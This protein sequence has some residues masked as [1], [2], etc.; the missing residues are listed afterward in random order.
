MKK[1]L[2]QL[3]YLSI[4]FGLLTACTS[5]D[6]DDP[7]AVNDG[8]GFTIDVNT[9]SSGAILVNPLNPDDLENTEV[10]IQEA[11]VTFDVALEFG[12]TENLEKVQ[13]VKSYNGEEE[14]VVAESNS[15]PFTVELTSID[16]ILEGTGVT[17]PDLRIGDQFRFRTKIFLNS[18]EI[19]YFNRNMGE[20]TIT[21]QCG[22]DLE[23]TYMVN[24]SG[25]PKDHVVTELSPGLYQMDTMLGWPDQTSSYAVEFTDVCGTLSL[26]N[27]SWA[28]SN[29]IEGEGYVAPNGDL[30]WTS[31]TVE[32]VYTGSAYTMIRQ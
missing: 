9:G 18:G 4:G 30:V 28:F 32:A 11:Y 23:A 5:D 17:V 22:S 27:G 1:Y 13:I 10:L 21:V 20:Q 16:E 15:I 12:S 2:K 7:A 26:I 29:A 8:P 24:Y 31:V 14:V 6:I 19:Y 3:M 25:G